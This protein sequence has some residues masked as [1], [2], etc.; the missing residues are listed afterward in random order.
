MFR[1]LNNRRHSATGRR[2]Q[3]VHLNQISTQLQKD[4][5]INS[6]DFTHKDWTLWK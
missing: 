4:L 3:R 6:Q 5:G 1:K 2:F